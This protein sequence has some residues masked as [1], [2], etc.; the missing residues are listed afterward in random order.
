MTAPMYAMHMG[1]GIGALIAPLVAD[2]FL[3][4]LEFNDTTNSSIYH[5]YT[6]GTS[7]SPLSSSTSTAFFESGYVVVKD[8]RVHLA[9]LAFGVIITLLSL[10][11]ILYPCF[12]LRFFRH[13]NQDGYS[14]LDSTNRRWLEIINPA[15]YA[16]GSFKYGLFVFVILILYFANTFGS[17]QM[18]GSFL[19]TFSVD[20]LKF[21]R[22]DASYLGMVY[23]GAF[24]VARL[25]GALVS[26]CIEIQTLFIAD[27]SL[28]LTVAILANV[29]AAGQQ[30]TLWV[31]SVIVGF[32]Q[33]P[34][35]PTGISYA[36]TQIEVGG[37]VLSLTLFASGFGQ[38]LYV[39][40]EGAL[41]ETYGTRTLLNVIQGSAMLIFIVSIIF[42]IVGYRRRDR[43]A[44]AAHSMQLLNNTFDMSQIGSYT[45]LSK[46]DTP[47][48]K[49]ND[50]HLFAA[51]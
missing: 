37:A 43:F 11:F 30:K 10:P 50:C 49:D 39:W 8:S 29:F 12:H 4:V 7:S 9:F 2:P 33:G 25:I 41:Y 26:P 17:V 31:F 18:F 3:A 48:D 46:V 45:K 15:K 5:N 44:R 16:D 1:F 40:I 19:R 20:E 23:W 21:S 24:T 35:H 42:V 38:M 36:N 13:E 27:I 51:D 6:I 14:N 34:L 32:F 47:S 22:D 28:Y